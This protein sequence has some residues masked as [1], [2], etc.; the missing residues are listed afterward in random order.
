MFELY[1][2]QSH[3]QYFSATCSSL[4]FSGT[5]IGKLTYINSHD[6]C[7][8]VEFISLIKLGFYIWNHQLMIPVI[9]NETQN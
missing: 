3:H 1:V 9:Y 5:L 6:S 7:Q 4:C 2:G 8:A